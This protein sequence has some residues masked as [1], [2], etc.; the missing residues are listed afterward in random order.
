MGVCPSVPFPTERY[1]LALPPTLDL[2]SGASYRLGMV[3]FRTRTGRDVPN[4]LAEMTP[5]VLVYANG[6][7][8]PKALSRCLLRLPPQGFS[9]DRPTCEQLEPLIYGLYPALFLAYARLSW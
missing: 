6:G 2:C 4:L 7:G 5:V 1:G 8:V 9:G 3:P